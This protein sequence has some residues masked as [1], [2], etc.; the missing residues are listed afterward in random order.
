[1]EY[2]QCLSLQ[3][4][5]ILFFNQC[6]QW[7][8]FKKDFCN[9]LLAILHYLINSIIGLHILNL[10]SH[11]SLKLPAKTIIIFFLSPAKPNFIDPKGNNYSL[12]ELNGNDQSNCFLHTSC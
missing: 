6:N 12:I 8:Q 10:V 1:M 11:F 2:N 7:N 5:L 4:L 9:F 3:D